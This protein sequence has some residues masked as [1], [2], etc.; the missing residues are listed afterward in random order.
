MRSLQDVWAFSPTKLP[1]VRRNIQQRH[2]GTRAEPRELSGSETISL[3]DRVA[4]AAQHRD[5]ER[6]LRRLAAALTPRELRGVVRSI[7]TWRDLRREI[8]LMAEV[9]PKRTF[10]PALWKAWQQHPLTPEVLTLL[11][12]MSERFG[13]EPAVG[14]RYAEE[15][16]NWLQDEM[17]LDA[18][19]RWTA[20]QNIGWENLAMLPASPF[21]PDTPL[22]K[23]IFHRTLQMGSSGQLLRMSEEDVLDGWSEMSGEGR[24]EACVNYIERVDPSYWDE[25]RNALDGIRRSY[26]LPGGS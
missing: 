7:G 19:V 24:K 1:A 5:A 11:L 23:R 15:G 6:E 8:C 17:P 18:I 4:A 9:R 20:S 13:L 21:S 2:P 26:G 22:I 12:A 10:V 16:A 14:E 3:R 25:S